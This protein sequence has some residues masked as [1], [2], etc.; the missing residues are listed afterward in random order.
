MLM[1]MKTL[2]AAAALFAISAPVLAEGKLSL[3]DVLATSDVTVSGRVDASYDYANTKGTAAPLFGGF[4]TE[5]NSFV[6]HQAAIN[7][8]KAP[9]SGVG[10]AVTILGGE[11]SKTLTGTGND[12]TVLQGYVSYT[13]GA[14]SVIGGRFLTLA[15]AEV[16]DSSANF[17]ATRGLL[18]FFQPTYHNGVRGTYK[19]SDA[20]S[21]TG[22]VVNSIFPANRDS[23][24]AAPKQKTV[25]LNAVYTVAGITN[26]LTAYVGKESAVK[27]AGNTTLIDYV[28]S[29]P[30]TKELT[31]VLNAD[32]FAL[33]NSKN[34]TS[35]GYGV[36]TYANYKLDAANRVAGRAE[37]VHQSEPTAFGR[38]VSA[39]T[40][41]YG[42]TVASNL[43]VLVEGRADLSG[44]EKLFATADP[45]NQYIGTVK[46][47]Y[48]F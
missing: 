9:A 38:N 7:N 17:N 6:L 14:V 15:G 46:A 13:Q 24:T 29:Y 30:V 16:I 32:Y 18:F 33:Q 35:D 3:T 25:E 23:S 47:I 12:L 36:A 39:V 44:S 27:D 10:G 31:L 4:Q 43:E 21:F 40:L 2:A 22:G 28:G 26:A 1:K 34:D 41:T 11:D 42:R 20:L 19:V 37:Y 8:V 48:K 5:N 45:S